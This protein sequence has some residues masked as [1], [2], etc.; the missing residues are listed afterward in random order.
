MDSRQRAEVTPGRR[1]RRPGR[2]AN[3]FRSGST[4]AGLPGDRGPGPPAAPRARRHV[5]PIA[6]AAGKLPGTCAR[7][8]AGPSGASS[9]TRLL[10]VPSH[11]AAQRAHSNSLRPRGFTG[12]DPLPRRWRGTCSRSGRPGSGIIPAPA[13]PPVRRGST[14]SSCASIAS[15]LL[16][17]QPKPGAAATR[18]AGVPIGKGTT[19]ARGRGSPRRAGGWTVGRM[20]AV[21]GDGLRRHRGS[22]HHLHQRRPLPP[23]HA[24]RPVLAQVPLRRRARTWCVAMATNK[25]GTATRPGDLLRPGPA[26]AAPGRAHQRHRRRLHRPAHLRAHRRARSA[27]TARSR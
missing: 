8:E 6:L 7:R 12:S 10:R 26:G 21:E 17:A 14:C 18:E 20:I 19:A 3:R 22:H 4:H 11:T 1:R 27:P 15:L 5:E 24:E 9:R 25:G 13:R 2:L 16:A 23:P